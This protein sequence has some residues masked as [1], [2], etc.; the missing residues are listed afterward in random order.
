MLFT[1]VIGHVGILCGWV[2]RTLWVDN[3]SKETLLLVSF[4]MSFFQEAPLCSGILDVD[5]REI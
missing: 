5:Y 2:T 1:Q 4:R 3:S